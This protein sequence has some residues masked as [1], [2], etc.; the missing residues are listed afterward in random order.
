MPIMAMQHDVDP[1][2][3]I[4][5]RVGDTPNIDVFGTHV[6]VAIYMR[7]EV[8]GGGLYLPQQYRD[9]DK[10]QSKVGLII[11]MGK[12]AFVEPEQKWFDGEKFDL[13]DWVVF[14]PSDGWDLTL[15]STKPGD[16]GIKCRLLSDTS[17]RGRVQH[18]DHVW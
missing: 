1:A 8:T 12:K 14:R 2:K 7:P 4:W 11:K 6:L 17:V 16:N 10:Y 18:P 15:P 3:D 9:E 5:K 13:G